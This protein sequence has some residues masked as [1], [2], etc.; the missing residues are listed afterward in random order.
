MSTSVLGFRGILA[1]LLNTA[2]GGKRDYYEVFGYKKTLTFDDYLGKFKRQDVAKRIISAPASATWRNPPVLKAPKNF[3]KDWDEMV[4]RLKLWGQIERVD[5]LAGLGQYSVLF[6]GIDDNKDPKLP[7]NKDYSNEL[8]FVQPYAQPNA[9]IKTLED[10]IHNPRYGLPKTYEIKANSGIE[11]EIAGTGA[12]SLTKFKSR[13]ME[14]HWSRIVHIAEDTLESNYLGT[15][16]LEAV[17]NILDDLFKVTGGTAETYWMGSNRGMQVDIDKDAQLSADDADDLADE[18]DEYQ[19]QLRR[20]IRTRGVKVNPLGGMTPDPKNTFDVLISLISGTTGIPK[21]VLTGSEAGQLASDQD[22]A[23]WAD[24]IKERRTTF[25]EPNVLLP[26]LV[27]LIDAGIMPST[28]LTKI[29]YEWPPNFQLTPLEEAQGMAQKGRALVNLSKMFDEGVQP[30]ASIEECRAII[31]LPPKPEVGTLP[32]PR[33]VTQTKVP[34]KPNDTS[35]EENDPE[36]DPNA[37]DNAGND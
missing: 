33:P 35:K 25:A 17:Y 14:V 15:P 30:I 12:A 31:G 8:L 23:N 28:D 10:D 18:I 7:V 11:E 32:A 26:L 2:F 13:T 5:R 36:N 4:Q 19:H 20:V 24:R 22:R 6:L 27:R 1:G 37:P 16:R 21:R 3:L 34:G 29:D 9:R